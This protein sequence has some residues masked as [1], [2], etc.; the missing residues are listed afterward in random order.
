M[1][2]GSCA[3]VVML[4]G[5]LT[6]AVILFALAGAAWGL[7]TYSQ[8]RQPDSNYWGV[9]VVGEVLLFVQAVSGLVMVGMGAWPTRGVHGWYGVASAFVWPLVWLYT[10]DCAE[11]RQALMY[12]LASLA[13]VALATRAMMVA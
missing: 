8:K 6:S 7:W 4:H 13:L 12:G 10:R 2:S 11:Q 9:L 3:I 5:R 1:M